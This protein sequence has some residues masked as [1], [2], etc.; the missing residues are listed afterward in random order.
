MD[1]AEQVERLEAL[2]RK[3]KLAMDSEPDYGLL[4]GVMASHVQRM[5]CDKAK[6]HPLDAVK[7]AEDFYRHYFEKVERITNM[8]YPNLRR[9]RIAG[10]R[11]K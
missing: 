9:D 8:A 3:I 4:S 7:L 10:K 1:Y 5:I 6:N 11:F 2:C